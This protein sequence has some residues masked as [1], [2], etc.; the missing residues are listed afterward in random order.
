MGYT[1][2]VMR[3]HN[4]GGSEGYYYD[5][6]YRGESLF[7]AIRVMIKYKKTSGCVKLLWR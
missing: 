1:W 3:W 4:D 2:E 6:V 7:A 5:S